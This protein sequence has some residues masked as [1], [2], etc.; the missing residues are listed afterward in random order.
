MHASKNNEASKAKT[1]APVT[2]T[3]EEKNNFELEESRIKSKKKK[4]RR[5]KQKS[6]KFK[7]KKGIKE[8]SPSP[9]ANVKT[10]T[11]VKIVNHNNL[12]LNEEP[13]DALVVEKET[14]RFRSKNKMRDLSDKFWKRPKLVNVIESPVKKEASPIW[15]RPRLADVLG[16]SKVE[17]GNNDDEKNIQEKPTTWKE[18]IELKRWKKKWSFPKIPIRL[19]V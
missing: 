16:V 8:K 1:K 10:L 4:K 5:S 9:E 11:P 12:I 6:L 14:S 17:S 19:P 13:I 7:N 2:K 15:K 3:E 18:Y